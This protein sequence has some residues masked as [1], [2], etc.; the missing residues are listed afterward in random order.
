MGSAISCIVI[1]SD[2]FPNRVPAQ[3]QTVRVI[4]E[5]GSF[6]VMEVDHDRQIVQL[7]E[8]WGKHRLIDVPFESVRIF[9]R[10]LAHTIRRF[11]DAREE[12][13]AAETCSRN[14]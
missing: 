2:F 9:N 5:P 12:A 3:G 11:L 1:K 10:S 13:E 8:R 14:G 7:M 6:V 4:G